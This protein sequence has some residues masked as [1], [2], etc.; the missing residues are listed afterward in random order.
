[1]LKEG[2]FDQPDRQRTLGWRR[3]HR[4]R[5]HRSGICPRAIGCRP[6]TVNSFSQWR[7]WQ[8]S[9]SERLSLRETSRAPQYGQITIRLGVSILV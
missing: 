2:A 3:R 1:V 7:Q 8:L 9:E 4:H 6:G 5:G